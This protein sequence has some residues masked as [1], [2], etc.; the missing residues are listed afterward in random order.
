MSTATKQAATKDL[1]WL[2]TLPSCPLVVA[3][4]KQRSPFTGWTNPLH[5]RDQL[6]ICEGVAD[7]I[8]VHTSE[9][10]GGSWSHLETIR[11]VTS[12]P[13][14]AKGFHPT[15]LDVER[16]LDCLGPR[17]WVLTVGW[18]GGCY[19]DRCWFEV[20]SRHHLINAPQSDWIVLNSR[21]PRTGEK[22]TAIDL[23]SDRVMGS[24]DRL[25]HRI[26]QASHIRG[27]EDVVPGVDAILIGEGLYT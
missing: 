14:L 22:R 7:I 2:R 11:A 25:G 16:A 21:N 6:A 17:D 24:V 5:W 27:P 9:L 19:H 26:C 13:I 20:E 15:L 4:I 3:E 8:S 12:K 1:S 10:W 23:Q 18:D